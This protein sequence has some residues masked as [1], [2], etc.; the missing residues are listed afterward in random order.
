M[1]SKWTKK[2]TEKLLAMA[3][4]GQ[5][6]QKATDNAS[7]TIVAPKRTKITTSVNSEQVTKSPFPRPNF[8]SS[9]NKAKE[10][11]VE[12]VL[13]SSEAELVLIMNGYR[14]LMKDW[15]SPIYAFFHL[16]PAIEYH[17]QHC[18][19]VFK[20]AAHGC[21]HKVRCYLDKKDTKST[22]NM[23]NSAEIVQWVSE[24]RP[25]YYIPAPKT[26]DY[27]GKLNFAT[28]AWTSPNHQ[29]YVAVSVHLEHE[30]QLLSMILDIIEVSKVKVNGK[31]DIPPTD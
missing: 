12:D 11:S 3:A 7:N 29:A 25:E 17:D 24:R 16:T 19:H 18:C 28:D 23:C 22:S 4:E 6:K 26:V 14:K 15:V 5:N 1:L 31:I 10:S 21:N 9:H 13:E 20:C 27:T 8:L 30:G 2:P